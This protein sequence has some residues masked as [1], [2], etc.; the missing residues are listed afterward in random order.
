M[1]DKKISQL[2][3]ATLPLA[4][5]ETVPIVQSGA[6][7]KT[8][9][10]SFVNGRAITP[11]QVTV[12]GNVILN[13]GLGSD[14]GLIKNTGSGYGVAADRW[15][16]SDGTTSTWFYNVPTGGNHY[17]AINQSNKLSITADNVNINVGN[18]VIGTSGKGIVLKSPNGLITKTLTIDNAGLI[19]L[20]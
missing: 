1:A 11:T 8:P 18:L 20:I 19:A 13:S 15:I 7:V 6:T 4:G 16:G 10:T 17:F 9:V 2:S 3:S 12:D 5:T 14:V